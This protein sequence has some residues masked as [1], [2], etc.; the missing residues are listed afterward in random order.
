MM[1]GDEYRESLRDGRRIFGHG[2]QIDD[3]TTDPHTRLAVDWIADGYDEF[4][5]PAPDAHGPYF[6]IPRSAD[7]LREAEERQKKYGP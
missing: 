5:D 4:Y 7:E 1:T 3:V 2:R 6:F